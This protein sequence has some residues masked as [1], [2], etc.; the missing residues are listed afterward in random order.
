ME[1][2]LYTEGDTRELLPTALELRQFGTRVVSYT[3]QPG[4]GLKNIRALDFPLPTA[5]VPPFRRQDPRTATTRLGSTVKHFT[6]IQV[7]DPSESEGRLRGFPFYRLM[8]PQPSLL[9]LRGL[10]HFR[11]QQVMN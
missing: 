9:C 1:A 6:W 2:F 11:V 7:T 3:E 4:E 5:A 8:S 10:L